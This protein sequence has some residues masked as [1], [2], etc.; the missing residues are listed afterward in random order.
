MQQGLIE[1]STLVRSLASPTVLDMPQF[2]ASAIG[3]LKRCFVPYVL[4]EKD[5][6]PEIK[7]AESFTEDGNAIWEGLMEECRARFFDQY[8]PEF[9]DY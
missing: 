5:R 4:L 8:L 2:S 9:D 1:E 7:R 3:G 6:W